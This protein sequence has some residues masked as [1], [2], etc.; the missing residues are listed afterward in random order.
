MAISTSDDFLMQCGFDYSLPN[1][2]R[3]L[4]IHPGEPRNP[5]P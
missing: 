3:A 4:F 2:K 1:Q 5:S